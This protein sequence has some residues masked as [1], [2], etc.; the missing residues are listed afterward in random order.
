MIAFGVFLSLFLLQSQTTGAFVLPS[1]SCSPTASS[2]SL[3]SW[4]CNERQS[5]P[6]EIE[7]RR[8]A[9]LDDHEE[10][11]DDDDDEDEFDD[12]GPLAKGIDSVSWLP[13]VNGA[14]G[15]NMPIDSAAEVRSI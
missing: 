11:E 8:F 9:G 15:D 7:T 2:R 1:T 12:K 10:E 14:K 6:R 4:Y 5:L 3:N 13:T